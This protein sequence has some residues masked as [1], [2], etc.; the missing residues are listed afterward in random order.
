M[1]GGPGI[2]GSPRICKLTP[3]ALPDASG[4]VI[5]LRSRPSR[6]ILDEAH[7]ALLELTWDMG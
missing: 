1:R 7:A 4:L 2:P 6:L 3:T 5:S